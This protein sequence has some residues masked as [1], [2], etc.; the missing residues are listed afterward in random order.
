MDAAL[1]ALTSAIE[2]V[3][4]PQSGEPVRRAPVR[5]E[6]F[7]FPALNGRAERDHVEIKGGAAVS[8]SY[9]KFA[10]NPDTGALSIKIVNAQTDEVIREIPPERVQRIAEELQAIARRSAGRGAPGGAARGDGVDHY[11]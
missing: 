2:A 9:A 11:A 7:E 8:Q 6:P 5:R 4:N 3:R 1:A 10:V